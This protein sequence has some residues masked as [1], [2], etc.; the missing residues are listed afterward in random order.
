[1]LTDERK[2]ELR[3]NYFSVLERI[4]A[5]KKKRGGDAP[6]TLLAA[7]KTM[8]AEDTVF[9]ARECGMTLCGENHAQEF[10]DK[11]AEVTAAG[12][13]MDFIG[14]LQKNKVKYVVGKAGLIHSVD[15]LEIA[16]E[17]DR[18]AARLGLIQPV[19]IEVN[20][21]GEESKTGIN[22]SLLPEL[23][24]KMSCFH[25]LEVR[26]MMAMTPKCEKIEENRKYFRESYEIF[27]DIFVKKSHNIKESILSM[28]MSDSFEVAIEEGA[29]LVRVGTSIF[30]RR[31]YGAKLSK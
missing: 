2:N 17:I 21:G 31:D 29:T 27:L 1:M 3:E 8:P 18:Q 12:C 23:Y 25:S 19:L 22:S 9:L 5:A 28:G 7:S 10:R 4:E 16:E 30:G 26:G 15:S 13:R 11:F 14:H 24:E 20:I 6:V